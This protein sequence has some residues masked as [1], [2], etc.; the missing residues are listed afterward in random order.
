MT[1]LEKPVSRIIVSHFNV[2]TFEMQIGQNYYVHLDDCCVDATFISVLTEKNMDPN[3]DPAEPDNLD[4]DDILSYRFA[5]GVH[6]DGVTR[7]ILIMPIN[8]DYVMSSSAA[9]ILISTK[10][11]QEIILE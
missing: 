7:G 6:V 10:T 9:N 2:N 5:N 11:G 1:Q 8:S 3:S 4:A